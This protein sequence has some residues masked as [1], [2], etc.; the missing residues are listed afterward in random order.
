MGLLKEI[1]STGLKERLYRYGF[2]DIGKDQWEERFGGIP[3]TWIYVLGRINKQ[4]DKYNVS[5]SSL[6][7]KRRTYLAEFDWV[8]IWETRK[9][10]SFEEALGVLT[11]HVRICQ[12]E[13][14][15]LLFYRQLSDHEI[16]QKPPNRISGCQEFLDNKWVTY[17]K[18]I[19]FDSPELKPLRSLLTRCDLCNYF[20]EDNVSYYDDVEKCRKNYEFK[21]LQGDLERR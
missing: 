1:F 9:Y 15:H 4:N 20:D 3:P 8:T 2:E 21:C 10:N 16:K 6:R 19:Y 12:N 13:F 5:V 18:Y 14:P 17:P 11:K 7:H